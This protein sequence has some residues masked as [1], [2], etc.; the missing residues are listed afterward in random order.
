LH[1]KKKRYTVRDGIRRQD[2]RSS[3][4]P[5][6]WPGDGYSQ[7]RPVRGRARR[8]PR[9]LV[10]VCTGP[11][12]AACARPGGHAPR[13]AFSAVTDCSR[14]GAEML[15][16]PA[17]IAPDRLPTRRLCAP[18]LPAGSV[19]RIWA[20]QACC[21]DGVRGCPRGSADGSLRART[22]GGQRRRGRHRQVVFTQVGRHV[23]VQ[24]GAVCKASL[25]AC[26]VRISVVIICESSCLAAN[27]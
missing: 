14:G 6:V 15:A 8:P 24:A 26:A 9:E 3:A 4:D 5:G 18:G 27:N 20:G 12:P 21:A 1:Y 11:V 16:G 25:L 7:P 22:Y 19:L 10:A 23:E 17:W 2:V 13:A